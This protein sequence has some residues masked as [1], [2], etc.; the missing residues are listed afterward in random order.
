MHSASAS[1]Q[2]AKI[3]EDQED[4][5][6]PVGIK[7]DSML[8]SAVNRPHT[9]I[10]EHQKYKTLELKL[11]ALFH[12]LTKN[13]PFH[14]GNKRTAL[15]S[16]L[17]A[18]HRNDKRLRSEVTD[19]HIYDFV[20]AVTADEFPTKD[21]DFST[22][23]VVKEIAKW[24]RARSVARTVK[25]RNMKPDEFI[26]NIKAAGAKIKKTG[27]TYIVNNENGSIRFKTSIKSLPGPVIRQYLNELRLNGINTGVSAEEF[28]DGTQ[29]EE[30]A[31]IYRFMAALQRLAKT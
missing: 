1:A 12:S 3:F 23:E 22:D 8:D 7:S 25:I 2:L 28:Q 30:R 9:G 15:V 13:H 31:L 16:L 4:P 21:H 5:I 24:I 29:T 19:D 20:V 14:N 18:L 10:G 26:K 17:T 27:N 6:S 11:A